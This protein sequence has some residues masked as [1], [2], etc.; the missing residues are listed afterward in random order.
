MNI[1]KSEM[2][3]RRAYV[4]DEELLR[5]YCHHKLTVYEMD[6]LLPI[7]YTRIRRRLILLGVYEGYEESMRRRRA[8]RETSRQGR[9]R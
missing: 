7:C 3:R 9:D 6:K 1:K 2:K 4:S 5:L 8:K